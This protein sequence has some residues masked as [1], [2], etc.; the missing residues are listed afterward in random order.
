[1]FSQVSVHRVGVSV[2]GVKNSVHRG[3]LPQCML[4]YHT[5]LARHSP[6]QGH[7]LWQWDPPWP[8]E[9]PWQRDPCSEIRSTSGRYVSYWNAILLFVFFFGCLSK[10]CVIN[11][12][13]VNLPLPVWDYCHNA[14]VLSFVETV[15]QV[16]VNN[17]QKG[18]TWDLPVFTCN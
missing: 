15:K 11:H 18:F 7:P 5:T 12:E 16:C 6:W 1:M 2:Q 3:A 4:G 14:V 17:E 8:G 13:Y 9:C 10:R